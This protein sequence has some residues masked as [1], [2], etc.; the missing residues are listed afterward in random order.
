VLPKTTLEYNQ[1]HG[2]RE[3]QGHDEAAHK[4][5]AENIIL[6]IFLFPKE[7]GKVVCV[8]KASQASEPVG[9]REL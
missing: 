6:R 5:Q 2:P 3:E 7:C 4:Y 9:R 1:Q 8:T